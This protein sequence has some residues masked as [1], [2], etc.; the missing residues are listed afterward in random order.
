MAV[1]KAMQ[2]IAHTTRMKY[3]YPFAVMPG[4]FANISYAV[5]DCERMVP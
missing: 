1:K 2:A 4:T 5:P 3:D